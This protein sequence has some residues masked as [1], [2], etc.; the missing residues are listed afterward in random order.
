MLS[1]VTH[2]HTAE[3]RAALV[4][5]PEKGHEWARSP[6]QQSQLMTLNGLTGAIARDHLTASMSSFQNG[7][8]TESPH[9]PFA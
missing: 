4:H 2:C 3:L 7:R 5:G 8:W 1:L 9:L 6:H